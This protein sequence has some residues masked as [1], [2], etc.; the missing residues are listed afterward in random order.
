M[1]KKRSRWKS[2]KILFESK[3]EIEK[4][5]ESGSVFDYKS[6]FEKRR[7][8]HKKRRTGSESKRAKTARELKKRTSYFRQVTTRKRI[9]LSKMRNHQ[10]DWMRKMKD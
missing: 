7:E 6:F 10:K 2:Q 9:S 1:E 3:A 8:T 4:K 5:S